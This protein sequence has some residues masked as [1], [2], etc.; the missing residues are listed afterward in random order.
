M[1]EEG[2]TDKKVVFYHNWCKSC[3]LCVAF[4]PRHALAMGRDMYP[5]LANPELCNHCGL[6][7]ALCPDFAITVTPRR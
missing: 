5:Y 7:Q 1:A 3:E 2:E 4:C 6:C